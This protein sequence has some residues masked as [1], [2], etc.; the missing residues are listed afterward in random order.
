MCNVHTA[1]PEFIALIRAAE[2]FDPLPVDEGIW[3]GVGG[4]RDQFTSSF[5]QPLTPFMLRSI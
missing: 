1:P 2:I 5:I 3:E 4:F